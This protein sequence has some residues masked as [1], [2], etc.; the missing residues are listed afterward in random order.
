MGEVTVSHYDILYYRH[1]PTH[2]CSRGALLHGPNYTWASLCTEG[3]GG[4]VVF[5]RAFVSSRLAGAK[6]A[7]QASVWAAPLACPAGPADAV[8]V[9]TA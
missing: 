8:F 7:E 9:R 2:T 4:P 3:V 5:G 1:D 6:G